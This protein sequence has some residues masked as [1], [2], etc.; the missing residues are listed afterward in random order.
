MRWIDWGRNAIAKE[1]WTKAR[2]LMQA[3]F[4][5]STDH[6]EQ[7]RVGHQVAQAV[8]L[9]Q[10]GRPP[11]GSRRRDHPDQGLDPAALEVVA[12]RGGEAQLALAGGRRL[13]N[14]GGNAE[15]AAILR[16]RVGQLDQ[17]PPLC[18]V[19]GKNEEV[20]IDSKSGVD[21]IEKAAAGP[22]SIAVES[23]TR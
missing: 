4:A 12:D 18:R 20:V 23:L 1:D 22:R 15:Y 19:A 16:D 7:H 14:D 5:K 8:C 10:G 9:H 21:Q 6:G 17:V 13:G 3:R 2:D 11:I